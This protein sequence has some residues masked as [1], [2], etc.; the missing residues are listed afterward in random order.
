MRAIL[1]KKQKAVLL[2][3]RPLF[4]ISVVFCPFKKRPPLGCDV[5]VS[6]TINF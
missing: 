6:E 1:T 3:Q 4:P 5:D 2:S